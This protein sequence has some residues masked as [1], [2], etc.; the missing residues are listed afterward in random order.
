MSQTTKGLAVTVMSAI[1]TLCILISTQSVLADTFIVQEVSTEGNQ[2]V[3]DNQIISIGNIP[4]GQEYKGKDRLS[5]SGVEGANALKEYYTRRGY[6]KVEVKVRF[7]PIKKDDKGYQE[8]H[9]KYEIK[10]NVPCRIETISIKTTNKVLKK[11]A[12]AVTRMFH[13]EIFSDKVMLQIVRD[14]NQMFF[15][16]KYLGASIESG[17][18]KY[19]NKKTRVSFNYQINHAY[20]YE[21][22]F[23]GNKYLSRSD[24]LRILKDS[25]LTPSSAKIQSRLINAY[26]DRGFAEVQVTESTR[27]NQKTSTQSLIFNIKEGARVRIRNIKVES[28]L[29]KSSQYKKFIIR[30]SSSLIKK[31][32]YKEEGLQNGVN[33]LINHLKNNGYL[34]AQHISTQWRYIN[35]KKSFGVAHVKINEGPLTRIK[36][37]QFEGARR[38][39]QKELIQQSELE[40]G[41]PLGDKKFWDSLPKIEKWYKKNGFLEFQILNDPSRAKGGKKNLLTTSEDLTEAHLKFILFEGEPIK[42][43]AIE[44]RGNKFTK[45]SVILNTIDLK[46]GDI[47]TSSSITASQ[48]ALLYLGIFSRADITFDQKA[49]DSLRKIT[50]RVQEATPGTFKVGMGVTNENGLTGRL[51][52][53]T[54]YNNIRGTGRAVNGRLNYKINLLK[55]H[56]SNEVRLTTGYTEPHLFG[57]KW[58]GKTLSVFEKSLRDQDSQADRYVNSQIIDFS[59][60][61][62]INRRVKFSWTLWNYTQRQLEVRPRANSPVKAE[63]LSKLHIGQ[64]GPSLTFDYRDNSFNP[65]KGYYSQFSSIYASPHLGSSSSINFIRFEGNFRHYIDLS[66]GRWVWANSYSTGYIK[67]LLWGKGESGIPYSSF[68]FL[69]GSN[70]LRAF[71]GNNS[72]ERIPNHDALGGTDDQFLGTELIRTEEVFYHLIRSEL[73]FPIANIVSGVIF[74]DGGEVNMSDISQRLQWRQSYGLG[75]R[76]NSPIGPI[77][78]DYA[79]KVNPLRGIGPSG[80]QSER[81][82]RFHLS[83]GTF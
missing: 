60:N 25:T 7:L 12:L 74:Y 20:K 6:F 83:I 66:R 62:D 49:K 35:K 5:K 41:A 37:I 48:E 26:R 58:Q 55:E 36:S 57:S 70:S 38:F 23:Y 13:G 22:Y 64:L 30:N 2:V 73:R 76:L 63:L 16:E 39:S 31:G 65:T 54:S 9:L 78:V 18:L 81:E 53:G 45:D 75:L 33:N 79:R 50:I 59:L 14:L 34:R 56:L 61:R 15:K 17:D 80:R 52:L 19:N 24:I 82:Y 21:M 32:Y 69:G 77:S 29:K 8:V 42:I 47:L 10:E 11:K 67:D 27:I 3:E 44:I 1:L 68:F 4:I 46:V 40:V 72:L 71:G 51:Y 28:P 43:A